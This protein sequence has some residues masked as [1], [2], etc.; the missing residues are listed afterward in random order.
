VLRNNTAG[1]P[2][3]AELF[4]LPGIIA[5]TFILLTSSFTS[6]LAVLEMNKGNK[7]GLILWLGITALLGAA[8]IYLEVTEFIHLVHEGAAITTSAH[9]TSFYTLVGAH[10][11]HVT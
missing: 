1:G 4:A 5:S 8:F 9:W 2:T 7:N 10:G 6:G 3:G 11:L